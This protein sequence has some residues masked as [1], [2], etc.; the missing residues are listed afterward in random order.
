[1]TLSIYYYLPF[2]FLSDLGFLA[3][4]KKWLD[5]V[6]SG[7]M[8][9]R[10]LLLSGARPPF[11][12]HFS[13]SA[14]LCSKRVPSNES[15]FFWRNIK[16]ILDVHTECDNS[17]TFF[18]GAVRIKICNRSMIMSWSRYIWNWRTIDLLSGVVMLISIST[19]T[20]PR[21]LFARYSVWFQKFW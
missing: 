14:L 12:D 9:S 1:M 18:F 19:H 7:E 13:T 3:G 17:S 15:F 20:C 4:L 21:H 8:T 2:S 5:N 10:C 16:W 6:A 11:C